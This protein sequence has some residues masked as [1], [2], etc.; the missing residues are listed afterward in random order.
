MRDPNWVNC[1]GFHLSESLLDPST[2]G[3]VP[4]THST[5]RSD[6]HEYSS[7]FNTQEHSRRIFVY[8]KWRKE[9]EKGKERERKS[10]KSFFIWRGKPGRLAQEV[11]TGGVITPPVPNLCA[12]AGFSGKTV[13]PRAPVGGKQDFSSSKRDAAGILSE[14]RHRWIREFCNGWIHAV[15][16]AFLSRTS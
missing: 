11:C 10:Q 15:S 16:K 2:R 1:L 5:N 8:Y 4:F 9:T 6:T 14:F 13:G 7:S 12:S 3:W